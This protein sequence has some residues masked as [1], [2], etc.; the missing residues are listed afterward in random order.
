MFAC[1]LRSDSRLLLNLKSHEI[2]MAASLSLR[3]EV[4]TIRSLNTIG[5]EQP[6]AGSARFHPTFLPS[7]Q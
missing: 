1:T 2:P 5:V 7:D 3:G 4:R 6:F